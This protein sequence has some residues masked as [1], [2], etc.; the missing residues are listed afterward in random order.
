MKERGKED[1][2]V[3]VTSKKEGPVVVKEVF[4]YLY[5]YKSTLCTVNEQKSV[6]T[7]ER[8]D[9]GKEDGEEAAEKQQGGEVR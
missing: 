2:E 4:A 7:E 8:H 6:R 1:K 9:K 5:I 3:K